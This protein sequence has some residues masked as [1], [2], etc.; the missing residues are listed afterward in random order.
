MSGPTAAQ[1]EDTAKDGSKEGAHGS[2]VQNSSNLV[3]RS[4]GNSAGLAPQHFAS[5]DAYPAI[6]PKKIRSIHQ[7]SASSQRAAELGQYDSQTRL[8]GSRLR[9]TSQAS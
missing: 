2:Q 1:K 8:L 6:Q 9:S 7:A 3:G 5:K 4:I